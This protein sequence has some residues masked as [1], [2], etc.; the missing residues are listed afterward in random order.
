MSVIEALAEKRCAHCGATLDDSG[1]CIA[2]SHRQAEAYASHKHSKAQEQAYREK[3]RERIRAQE[4]AYREK[5]REQIRERCRAYYER[6]KD[7]IRQRDRKNAL[8]RLR[9]RAAQPP[10][11]R[12]EPPT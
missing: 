9:E 10:A 3:H 7:A 6:N 12:A 5:H 2:C 11:S 1:V 8:R 4:Q